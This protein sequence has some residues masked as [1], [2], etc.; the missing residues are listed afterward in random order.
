MYFSDYILLIIFPENSPPQNHNKKEHV[1][2]PS[3]PTAGQHLNQPKSAK[4]KNSRPKHFQNPNV[5]CS[6]NPEELK[7]EITK[8]GKDQDFQKRKQSYS[9]NSISIKEQTVLNYS[10]AE[11]VGDEAIPPT[12]EITSASKDFIK[13]KKQT[14]PSIQDSKTSKYKQ[15]KTQ[16]ATRNSD[17]TISDVSPHV[18]SNQTKSKKLSSIETKQSESVKKNLKNEDENKSPPSPKINQENED[19]SLDKTQFGQVTTGENLNGLKK[20]PKDLIPSPNHNISSNKESSLIVQESLYIP[21]EK[22]SFLPHS[23]TTKETNS[24]KNISSK[25]NNNGKVLLNLLVI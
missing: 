23:I 8:N 13:S 22:K 2:P 7:F 10:S 21:K 25:I 18:K 14:S 12:F 6:S 19:K 9:E 1:S 5:S 4:N 11:E 17:D 15:N 16:L 24:D 3:K 20:L